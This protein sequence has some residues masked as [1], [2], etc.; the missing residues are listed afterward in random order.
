[1]QARFICAKTT[2]NGTKEVSL[3]SDVTKAPQG[4]T[5]E[6]GGEEQ[7][8]TGKE[9]NH[10]PAQYAQHVDSPVPERFQYTPG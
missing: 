4:D 7:G 2:D 6:K 8:I 1:M 10:R 5:E 9:S 3:A